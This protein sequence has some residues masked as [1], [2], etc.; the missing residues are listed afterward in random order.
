MQGTILYILAM[1][2]ISLQGVAVKGMGSSYPVLELDGIIMG[3][4][5]LVWAG[6]TYCM[7]RAYSLAQ[8][9][10]PPRLSI[11]RCRSMCC[12]GLPSGARSRRHGLWQAPG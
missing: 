6:W 9:Q 2:I 10:Q 3:G 5:G 8:A 11:C 12:G 1:L 7:S 4:L